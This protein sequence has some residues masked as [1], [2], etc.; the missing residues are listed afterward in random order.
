MPNYSKSSQKQKATCT[1]GII[2]VFNSVIRWYDN[3]FIQGKRTKKEQAENLAAGKTT[4]MNSKHLFDPSRAADVTPYPVPK[5]WGSLEEALRGFAPHDR[6]RVINIF[7]ERAKFYHFA[8]YVQGQAQL[9]G[10]PLTWG[11]DWDGDK[12]F[13]DQ[14][15]DDLVHFEEP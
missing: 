13:A 8:G 2:G 10:N 3:R 14:T 15:F 7:K 6:R 11:G 1:P 5:D 12:D 4:T 9:M